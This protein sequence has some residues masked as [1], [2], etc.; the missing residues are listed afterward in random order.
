[1]LA[2]CLNGRPQETCSTPNPV[3]CRQT[4]GSVTASGRPIP[5][6]YRLR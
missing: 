5:L 4:N 1:M 2:G 6:R 3:F